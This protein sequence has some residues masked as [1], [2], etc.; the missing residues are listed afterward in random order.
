MVQ[1]TR[2]EDSALD[3]SKVDADVGVT[4]LRDEAR[5]LF[6]VHAGFVDPRVQGGV[7]DVVDL[8]TGGHAMV[9]FDGIGATPAEGVTRLEM[10]DELQGL[11]ERLDFRRG[12]FEAFPFASPHFHHAVP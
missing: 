2:G 7:V 8:L 11:H 10:V 5:M 4:R 1:C 9:Q 3:E 12:F 6:G